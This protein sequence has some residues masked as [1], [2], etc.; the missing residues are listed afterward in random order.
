MS[1]RGTSRRT[2]PH[3]E[4][5]ISLDAADLRGDMPGFMF[6][7]PREVE[8]E[9][10]ALAAEARRTGIVVS[11]AL[12]TGILIAWLI[13]LVTGGPGLAAMMGL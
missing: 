6:V 2:E 11:I 9:E 7:D 1:I 12:P 13:D 4:V 8:A 10:E 5:W 3:R